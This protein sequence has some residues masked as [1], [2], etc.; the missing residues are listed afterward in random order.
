M[1]GGGVG[2]AKLYFLGGRTGKAARIAVRRAERPFKKGATN[3]CEP[4]SDAAD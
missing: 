1:R 3:A 4:A 2:R